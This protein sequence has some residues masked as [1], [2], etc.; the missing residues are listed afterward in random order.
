[1]RNKKARRRVVF[2]ET[3][4]GYELKLLNQAKRCGKGFGVILYY[5]TNTFFTY[6]LDRALI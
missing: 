2:I 5:R 1:M 4:V 6:I 3:D